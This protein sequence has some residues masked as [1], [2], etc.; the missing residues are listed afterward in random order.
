MGEITIRQAQANT[1]EKQMATAESIKQ[2]VL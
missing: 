2:E 1:K